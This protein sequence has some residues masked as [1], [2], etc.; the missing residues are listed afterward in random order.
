[1]SLLLH[2]IIYCIPC[3]CLHTAPCFYAFRPF[4]LYILQLFSKI[5]LL[6]SFI[7]CYIL[8][9]FTAIASLYRYWNGQERNHLYMTIAC[10]IGVTLH[11]QIGNNGYICQGVQCYLYVHQ[12]PKSVPLYCYLQETVKDNFY[13]TNSLEIGTTTPGEIGNHG[14]KSEGIAGYCFPEMM[15]NTVPLYRYYNSKIF[16]HFYTTDDTEIDTV[17]AGEHGYAFEGIACFVLPV[18]N[19]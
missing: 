12:V 14:Y 6:L 3:L 8:H 13:T 5:I 15:S 7:L 9:L 17:T 16:D 1:M 19:T 18:D 11:G 2:A 10:E 4:D